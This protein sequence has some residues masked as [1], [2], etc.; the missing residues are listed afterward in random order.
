MPNL[1]HRWEVERPPVAY[2]KHL[3][4]LIASG[5]I[6]PK[7]G[8]N[9]FSSYGSNMTTGQIRSRGGQ[10]LCHWTPSNKEAV[11]IF[12]LKLLAMYSK[13]VLSFECIIS[14]LPSHLIY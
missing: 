12:H 3:L 5:E 14:P 6:H 7:G 10:L 2:V 4:H 9:F 11:A 8:F 1:G 13:Q